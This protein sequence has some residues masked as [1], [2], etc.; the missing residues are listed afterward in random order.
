M[1]SLEPGVFERKGEL[2]MGIRKFSLSND[3]LTGRASHALSLFDWSETSDA[4][5]V[6]SNG[7]DETWLICNRN[8]CAYAFLQHKRTFVLPISET[9]LKQMALV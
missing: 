2:D 5:F 6:L 9:L 4:Y 8:V 7:H 3:L 1:T